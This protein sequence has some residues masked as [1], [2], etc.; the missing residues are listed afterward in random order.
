[1]LAPK[2]HGQAMV[3]F[4]IVVPVV[5][6]L[7]FGTIQA[8]FIYS[9]K[10][11]LNYA[12]FQAARLGAVNHASYDGLRRGLIRGLTPMFTH[13]DTDADKTRAH[14]Q[15]GSEVDNYVRITRISPNLSDFSSFGQ[16]NNEKA[17]YS[18][19]N[20]NLMYRPATGIQDANLLKIRVQY[21]LALTVP[22][23]DRLLSA[24]SRFN[25]SR[26]EGSFSGASANA[27][28]QYA[29]ICQAGRRGIVITAE[30]TVRMQSNAIRDS[31]TC[32]NKMQC[33]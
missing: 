4:L 24:A 2:Q 20:D 27:V 30:T 32:A 6:M 33:L 26:I 16:W 17:D 29:Q 23:V 12:T 7:I 5:I 11:T 14:L 10:S 19:P 1:M 25:E 22:I 28:T 13:H 8:A 31:T 15:A 18:I 3:E 9:A 21:C